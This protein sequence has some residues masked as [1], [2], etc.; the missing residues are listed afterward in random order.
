M[1]PFPVR[2]SFSSA[3]ITLVACYIGEGNVASIVDGEIT[4]KGLRHGSAG[5][6]KGENFQL[7]PEAIE[8]L[9]ILDQHLL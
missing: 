3:V 9:Y 4:A 6:A 5:I 2:C 7:D 1:Y 8:H